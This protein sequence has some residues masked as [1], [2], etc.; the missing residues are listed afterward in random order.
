[1]FVE[2]GKCPAVA[3]PVGVELKKEGYSGISVFSKAGWRGF[4]SILSIT[5]TFRNHDIER[6]E[7][8]NY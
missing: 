4:V 3:T 5:S 1:M 6:N 8:A 2:R 7:F